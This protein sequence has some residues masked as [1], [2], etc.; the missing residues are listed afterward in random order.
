M[1]KV[2]VFGSFDVIHPGHEFFFEKAKE[3]GDYLIVVLARDETIRKIKNKEPYFNEKIRVEQVKALNIVDSC[4]LGSLGDKYQ[5]IIDHKPDVLIFGYDQKSFN[6]GI[7]KE[8]EKRNLD[9]EII[10][11]KESYFPDK[12]KS[13]IVVKDL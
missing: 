6:I 9:I 12:F 8:L 10:Q 11:L 2:M 4:V 7:E 13:S 5:V 1:R 3:Y